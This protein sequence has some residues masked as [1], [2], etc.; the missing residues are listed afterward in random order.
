MGVG[1]AEL[2]GSLREGVYY[3]Q[4]ELITRV[5][6]VLKEKVVG[7]ARIYEAISA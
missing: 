2:R 7:V 4:A 1:V 6:R 3:T 5:T